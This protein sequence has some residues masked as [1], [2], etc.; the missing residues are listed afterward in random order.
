MGLDLKVLE[1][2]CRDTLPKYDRRD[3]TLG[4]AEVRLANTERLMKLSELVALGTITLEQAN[5]YAMAP[6]LLWACRK[7]LAGIESISDCIDHVDC[8]KDG[9]Q[10][11]HESLEIVRGVVAHFEEKPNA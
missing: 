3:L 5:L 10:Q 6:S 11:W 2:F 1:A 4:Q 7:I 8:S 9:G